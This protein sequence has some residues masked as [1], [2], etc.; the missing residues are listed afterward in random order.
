MILTVLYWLVI[1]KLFAMGLLNSK[2]FIDELVEGDKIIFGTILKV[3]VALLLTSL[4]V[5]L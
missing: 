1:K 2:S 3:K 5:G 4:R